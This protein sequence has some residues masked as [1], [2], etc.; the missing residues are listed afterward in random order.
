MVPSYL[1]WASCGDPIS[2]S[3]QA[4]DTWR[5]VPKRGWIPRPSTGQMGYPPPRQEGV[6]EEGEQSW[7]RVPWNRART[8]GRTEPDQGE[9]GWALGSQQPALDP[10]LCCAQWVGKPTWCRQM[11]LIPAELP[12]LR[13]EAASGPGHAGHAGEPV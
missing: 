9:L 3:P 8:D 6:G 5:P 11:A 12:R 13:Q 7:L 1:H 10:L 4:S 2:A